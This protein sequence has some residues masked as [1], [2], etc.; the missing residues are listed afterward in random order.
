MDVK[1]MFRHRGRVVANKALLGGSGGT[2]SIPSSVSGYTVV[3][4]WT[5]FLT[6]KMGII[7][8]SFLSCLA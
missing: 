6:Y 1:Q 2:I 4:V 8:L 5:Q 3:R 7:L